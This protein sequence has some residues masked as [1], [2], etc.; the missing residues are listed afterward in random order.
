M[1][2][3]YNPRAITDG[4]VL[5]LDAGNPKNYNAGIST[6]WTDKVGGNN[7]TLF[8]GT[9]HT[10]GPFVGAGYVEFDGTG[11]TLTLDNNADHQ[12]GSSDY[13][14][15]AWVYLNNLSSVQGLFGRYNTSSAREIYITLN[16]DGS[17]TH[18]TS[19]NGTSF[20]THTS[21]TG[22]LTANTWHHVAISKSGTNSYIAVDGV[23]GSGTVDSTLHTAS[24]TTY[25]GDAVA[26]SNLLNGKLSNYR[27]LKGTALYTSNFTPPTK[28]LTAVTNTKL[29]TC[30]GNT[31]SPGTDIVV[32]T[33]NK[34]SGST[35]SLS[36]VTSSGNYYFDNR[37]AS[38]STASIQL[39]FK[40]VQTGVTQI[41]LS[42][43]GYQQ[44]STYDLYV[45]GVLVEN[46]RSTVT[47]WGEDTITISS[48]D[49]SS[50][51]IEGSDGY[52]LGALKFNGTLVSGTIS[53]IVPNGDISLTKEP[54][55][56]AGAFAFDGSGDY[57]D[58]ASSSDFIFDGDFTIEYWIY[59]EGGNVWFDIGKSNDY[60]N[61]IQFYSSSGNFN[62]YMNSST[63]TNVGGA[64]YM[65]VPTNQWV[66][67]AVSRSGTTCR[68]FADGVLKKTT[69][70]SGTAG[71]NASNILRLGAQIYG[72]PTAYF[73]G[74]LSNLRIVKGTALYT[75]DFTPPTRAL[76]P[77][78]NTVLLTCQGQNIKDYSSSAHT[79]TPNGNVKTTIVSSSFEFDGTDDYV[80]IPSSTLELDT[81]TNFTLEYW[82]YTST[83]GTAPAVVV[84]ASTSK[85]IGLFITNPSSSIN[86]SILSESNY[87]SS[88]NSV[89]LRATTD[90][91]TNTWTHISFVRLS[92][93][94]TIYINGV[95]S[96]T[97]S[98]AFSSRPLN[99]IGA[100]AQ[101][102]APNYYFLDGKIS[103][104][105]IYK[106][107][108]LT[109]AEVEQN[110]NASKGR[111]A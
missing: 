97:V 60:T 12:F 83:S 93:T 82:V 46:D 91:S 56:G 40:T 39:D 109:A 50:I 17:I 31:I 62:F 24:Q 13:T 38:P 73:Q 20:S 65:D 6:N 103:G 55:A 64:G 33:S 104:V 72:G 84:N 45:N 26:G 11:D 100:I 53:E 52:S 47:L 88:G 32:T 79:I 75:S 98:N 30:Q 77:I 66:H 15:E 48:T 95:A 80:T 94:I 23:V 96:G 19:S 10:D 34:G 81:N 49:I 4:L 76:E 16:T 78:E 111:Y 18:R 87:P 59:R 71:N 51:K 105:K 99:L 5:A 44:G 43:G 69:T 37:S 106:G 42:G 41:K 28:P 54:F 36:A 21:S 27:I 1:A 67:H 2:V 29:L 58:I 90:I 89:P 92:G 86:Y 35:G 14:I 68:V 57:V 70:L 22:L 85:I 108:G 25:I 101:G 8:G 7:G 107:K 3:G 9:H 61:A 63:A 110:Y 74:K 102:G